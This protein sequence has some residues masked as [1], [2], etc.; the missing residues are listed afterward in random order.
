MLDFLLTGLLL[1][2]SAGLS[3]G[4]LLTLLISETLQHDVRAGIKV[5]VSPLITDLPIIILSLLVLSKLSSFQGV[6]GILS[7]LGS[8]FLLL[9]AYQSVNPMFTTSHNTKARPHSLL[10]GVLVN[11]LNPHPYLFWLAVGVPL[12]HK[13][14]VINLGALLSFLISFYVLLVGSKIGIAIVIGQT[15]GF[16]STS[17]YRTAMRLL[18]V[19][20]CILA[21]LLFRD[22]LRLLNL[23][24]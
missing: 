17:Y 18:A 6:L 24:D 10:K 13:A 22:G 7:L 11:A 8:G 20:L 1:G 19:A 23:L 4:P 15:K 2:L 14:L 12:M 9:M 3:P 21:L 5:A 16:F